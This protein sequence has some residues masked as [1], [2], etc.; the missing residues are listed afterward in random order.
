MKLLFIT[1]L[2]CISIFTSAE[3]ATPSVL[4]TRISDNGVTLS[5]QINGYKNG[6]KINYDQTTNVSRLNWLQKELVKYRAF[7]SQGLF[8]PLREMPGLCMTASGLVVLMSTLSMMG[9]T[10]KRISRANHL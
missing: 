4:R 9:Y 7:R 6:R 3:A 8:L 2:L 10:M 1:L 5:I